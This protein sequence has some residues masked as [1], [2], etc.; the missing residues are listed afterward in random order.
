[1]VVILGAKTDMSIWKRKGVLQLR[2]R[3]NGTN[4]K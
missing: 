2:N 1:M 3:E 4:L